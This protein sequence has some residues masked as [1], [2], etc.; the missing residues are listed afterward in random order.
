MHSANRTSSKPALLPTRWWPFF[1]A[2]SRFSI[3]PSSFDDAT[4]GV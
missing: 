2:E 3:L 4:F 1:S